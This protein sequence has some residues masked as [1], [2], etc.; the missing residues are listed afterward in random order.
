[1]SEGPLGN[2]NINR[3]FPSQ[4]RE[5]IYTKLAS[6]LLSHKHRVR[7]RNCIGIKACSLVILT[8]CVTCIPALIILVC[9]IT[10]THHQQQQWIFWTIRKRELLRHVTLISFLLNASVWP[11]L[12][13]QKNREFRW[14]HPTKLLCSKTYNFIDSKRFWWV[15]KGLQRGVNHS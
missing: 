1:M 7:R 10:A 8:E 2:I 11:F 14:A 13:M 4:R 5:M 9:D 12:N 15:Y 3:W 6:K